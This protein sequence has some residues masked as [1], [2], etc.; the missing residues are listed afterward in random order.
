MINTYVCF[1]LVN[2]VFV[3]FPFLYGKLSW[4]TA[5]WN[6]NTLYLF[7]LKLNIEIEM[8]CAVSKALWSHSYDSADIAISSDKYIWF[9]P[10]NAVF[11]SVNELILLFLKEVR[12]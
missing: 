3:E 7:G 4:D 9:R 1:S 10:S 2:W 6:P 5:E 12:W 8:M 11:T